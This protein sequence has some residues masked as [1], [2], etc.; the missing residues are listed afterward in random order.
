MKPNDL[1]QRLSARGTVRWTFLI[2]VLAGALSKSAPLFA[3][4]KGKALRLSDVLASVRGL[5]PPYLAA[6]LEQDIANGRVRQAQGTGGPSWDDR[7]CLGC[8]SATVCGGEA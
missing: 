2:L 5:Y 3:E 1:S 7:E 6:L 8:P 4:E